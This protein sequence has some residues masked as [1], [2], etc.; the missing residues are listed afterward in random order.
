M[1][2]FPLNSLMTTSVRKSPWG[3]KTTQTCSLTDIMSE[4]LAVQISEEPTEVKQPSSSPVIEFKDDSVPVDFQGPDN[5]DADLAY[6]L[7]LAEEE[8]RN[9]EK[10]VRQRQLEQGSKGFVYLI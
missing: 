1:S 8:Q 5:T 4:Q 3:V 10:Y 7:Q 9:F 6:A 2:D